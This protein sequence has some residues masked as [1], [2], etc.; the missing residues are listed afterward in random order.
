MRRLEADYTNI[1]GK[2]TTYDTDYQAKLDKEAFLLELIEKCCR[3]VKLSGGLAIRGDEVALHM[4]EL[5]HSYYKVSALFGLYRFYCYVMIVMRWFS[6]SP[7][8]RVLRRGS[9]S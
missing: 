1:I 7:M 3:Y 2:A 5:A 6:I 4:M 9:R 8:T